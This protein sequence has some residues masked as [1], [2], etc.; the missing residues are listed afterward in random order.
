MGTNERFPLVTIAI[1]TYNGESGLPLALNSVM[2]QAYP[3]LEILISDNASTDN[4]EEVI[5]PFLSDER[6][7]YFRQ[8][9]NMGLIKNFNFLL[10]KATGKYFMW[11]GD[12]DELA[13]NIVKQYVSF[14][15]EN[16]SYALACGVINYWD[17]DHLYDEEKGLSLEAESAMWRTFQYY[18]KVAQ[19]AL[20]YGLFR[21]ELV[22]QLE[23]P[24]LIGNDWHFV[25]AA[26]F[27]G[28][29]KHL[30]FHAYNKN[31]GGISVDFHAYARAFKEPKIWGYFPFVK[32]SIDTFKEIM[33]INPVYKRL[34]LIKRL[35]LAT[36][37]MIGINFHYYCIILP[38]VWAGKILRALNLKTPR[39]K[40]LETYKKKLA[41]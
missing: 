13:P 32:I 17:K 31:A 28:K 5:Q 39:E 25:A 4:T 6:I 20:V 10:K 29:V 21:R 26:S 3:N 7:V 23:L 12:D 15:E 40:R 33:Y 34:G 14:L 16:P 1:P 19:G 9:E 18:R 2:N 24:P 37:S 30:D 8:A 35:I 38:K 22:S 41:K 27:L 36:S 11:L